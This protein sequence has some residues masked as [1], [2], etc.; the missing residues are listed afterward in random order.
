MAHVRKPLLCLCL[1]GVLFERPSLAQ[2][3]RE[4]SSDA[5]QRLSPSEELLRGARLLDAM[6]AAGAIAP[7]ERAAR[8]GAGPLAWF[9]LGLAYRAVGRRRAAI[10]AWE[11]YLRAPEPDA[12][13]ARLR[14][15][16]IERASLE[17]QCATLELR[18]SPSVAHAQ[19]D[20]N[21]LE[22]DHVD[23]G[24]STS[25]DLRVYRWRLDDGEH[26][27][28]VRAAGYRTEE[29]RLTL[30]AREHRMLEISLQRSPSEPRSS[31]G[32]GLDPRPFAPWWT[33]VGAG[34]LAVGAIAATALAIDGQRIFDDCSAAPVRCATNEA[35]VQA[36]LDAR[37][38]AIGISAGV[39]GAGLAVLV[40]GIVAGTRASEP[41]R[42]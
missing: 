7:L 4:P 33:W 29:R 15:V 30:R 27:V 20:D 32:A 38:T 6:D 24:S 18:V 37:S 10:D 26:R 22:P 34:A 25:G 41:R 13:E 1:A 36:A 21:A 19:V 5:A 35:A 12:P 9:N 40:T 31:G 3:P 17:E 16:R 42:R 14:A 23:R 2:A 39:G 11:R 28:A 8:G